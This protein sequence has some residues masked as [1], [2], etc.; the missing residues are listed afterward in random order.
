MNPND[1]IKAVAE[2]DGWK[3]IPPP[4]E[5]WS[6]PS[7]K[8]PKKT[9]W[10]ENGWDDPLYLPAYLTSRDAIVPVIERQ[11]DFAKIQTANYLYQVCRQIHDDKD[12]CF[13]LATPAQLCEAL[14]RAAGRWTD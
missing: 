12:V 3:I 7:L 9:A 6:D 8:P 11:D 14:L 10:F 5:A 1:K 13:M 2:L 4:S